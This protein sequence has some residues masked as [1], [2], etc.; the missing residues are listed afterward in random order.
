MVTTEAAPARTLFGD[1]AFR[2]LFAAAASRLGVQVGYLAVPLVAVS[3]LDASPGQV[4][5]LATL[6]TAAFLLIG[7]PA[8]AWVDRVRRRGV[9]IVADVVRA[10]LLGSVPVAWTMDTLTLPHLYVVVFVAGIGTVFF[11]VAAQS[12]LPHVVGRDRLVSANSALHSFDAVANIAGRGGAGYLVQWATAPIALVVTAVGYVASGLLLA[13]IGK[14][15]PAPRPDRE[16]GLWRQVGE[17]LGFVLRHPILRPAAMAGAA[18]NFGMQMCL[19]MLPVVIVSDLGLAEGRFGLFLAMGGVGALL[20]ALTARRLGAVLGL[21]RMLWLLGA[22]VAPAAAFVP[23]LDHGSAFWVAAAGWSVLAYKVGVDNVVL[24]SFRQR[25]TPDGLLGRQNA[26][27]RFLLT[28][29]LALG[30]AASGAIGEVVSARA[31]LW[32]GVVVLAFAW[33]P[34]FFSPVRRLRELPESAEKV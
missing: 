13:G 19:T 4:G 6:S 25:V 30:A 23:M 29:A 2:L 22:A 11:D 21:G 20:G 15:E 18:T 17:G 9:M 5:L 33:A 3:A 10:V 26:T 16:H 27:M 12:Y 31:A 24:V 1:P 28:G 14:R 7:L 32:A 34:L 8:G